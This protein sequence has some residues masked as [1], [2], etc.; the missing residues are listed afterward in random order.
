VRAVVAAS[1]FRFVV[2]PAVCSVKCCA[3]LNALR[4]LLDPILNM[5]PRKL[6][7]LGIVLV[8][9]I[10]PFAFAQSNQ[11]AASTTD[12][13]VALHFGK[14]TPVTQEAAQT[15]HSKAL[16]L[17]ETSNFNS[18]TSGLDWSISKIHEQYRQT[19]AG[20]YLLVSLIEPRRIKTVGGEVIVR[21]IVIGLNRPDSIATVGGV[22]YA[23]YA[24]SLFTI[25]DEGRLIVHAKYSGPMCIE[26]M[27]LVKKIA[28][29]TQ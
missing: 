27:K 19:V 29:E 28:G 5:T 9:A 21:E 22:S 11:P 4:Q 1:C 16:E 12:Y 18:R 7:P 26:L 25:D 24:S 13:T 23:D 2:Y 17:L 14:Q 15:L 10:T 6:L 8:T 20:K 3:S